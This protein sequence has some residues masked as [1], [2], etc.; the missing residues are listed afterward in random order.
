VRS[1]TSC[2]RPCV[3][4]SGR[5]ALAAVSGVEAAA[6]PGIGPVTLRGS[7]GSPPKGVVRFLISDFRFQIF[8]DMV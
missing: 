6:K 5:E 2:A 3:S 8:S 7:A 1:A 4:G